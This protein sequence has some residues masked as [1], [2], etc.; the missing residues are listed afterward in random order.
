MTTY[1]VKETGRH[2]AA[3]RYNRTTKRW[4][5]GGPETDVEI[6]DDDSGQL[7]SE[8]SFDDLIDVA[9]VVTLSEREDEAEICDQIADEV[10]RRLDELADQIDGWNGESA[11]E[12]ADLLND[13]DDMVRCAEHALEYV[14]GRP[15]GYRFEHTY[16]VASLGWHSDREPSASRNDVYACDRHGVFVV[17]VAG[18]TDNGWTTE[19]PE[20][21]E[22]EK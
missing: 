13:A 4:L 10:D 1:T 2:F 16:D 15:Y 6:H 9:A 19:E 7:L 11:R 3:Q 20:E 5:D 17:L 18:T 8:L 21:G 22:S 12:L 14:R